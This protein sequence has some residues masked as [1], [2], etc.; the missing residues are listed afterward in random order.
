MC[1]DAIWDSFLLGGAGWNEDHRLPGKHST[2]LH[3]SPHENP[4]NTS[5]RRSFFIAHFPESTIN[6]Q[7]AR[8]FQNTHMTFWGYAANNLKQLHKDLQV[9]L[10]QNNLLN[11][12][13]KTWNAPSSPRLVVPSRADMY[14]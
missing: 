9:C 2:E 5:R 4:H 8:L 11:G 6:A 14:R 1:S 13:F 12:N 10:Q 3:P 7:S